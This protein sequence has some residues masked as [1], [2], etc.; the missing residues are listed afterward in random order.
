MI[1]VGYNEDQKQKPDSYLLKD[2]I[3]GGK[4]DVETSFTVGWDRDALVFDIR[5]QEPDMKNMFIT[6]DVWS[7]DNVAILLEPPGHAYYQIE[8]N[9]EGQIFDADRGSGV[10]TRWESQVVVK[11]ERGK[12][13][14]QVEIRI[15]IAGE[16]DGAM[17]PNHFVVGSKPSLEFPWYINV[18]RARVRDDQMTIYGFSPV[19][20][21]TYHDPLKFAK[22]IVR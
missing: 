7:G 5:C 8:I 14:W 3:S 15:P 2:M 10:A 19:G 17:D 12:D 22:L 4:P 18:G 16:E 20:A 21:A 13:Y 1:A 11:T 9:P 6:E